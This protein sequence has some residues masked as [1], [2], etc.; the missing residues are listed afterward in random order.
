[1]TRGG[2]ER[3]RE[4]PERRC[5]ATGESGDTERMIRFVLGPDGALVPDLAEKLPG[6]GAWLTAER[7]LVEKVVAKRLFSRAF[8]AGVAA[9]PDLADRLEA[10]LAGRLIS[11][12]ALARKAGQAVCGFEKTREWLRSGRAGLLLE[13]SDGAADGRAKLRRIAP[14]VPVTG[15]LDARELGLAFG[16]DFAIH[17]ALE[18]GGVADRAAR[19]SNRLAGFRSPG[20]D[21]PAGMEGRGAVGAASDGN[22]GIE[23]G[24]GSGRDSV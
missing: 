23:P 3:R 7:A 1:M 8:R 24:T 11:L 12:I 17:A 6:R 19:E 10:L 13:A 15:L 5:I 18:A 22:H 20:G 4:E 21:A 16:R 2:R 14:G 9:P